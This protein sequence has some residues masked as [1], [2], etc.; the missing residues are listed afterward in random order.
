[1]NSKFM[2]PYAQR[3]FSESMA[4]RQMVRISGIKE[5][6]IP[7]KLRRIAAPICISPRKIPNR[8]F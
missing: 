3:K 1:M 5:I 7:A 2:M 4:S 6:G 8:R